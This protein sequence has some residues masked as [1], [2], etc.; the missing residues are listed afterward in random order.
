MSTV[1]S[2][3]RN[4]IA[5]SDIFMTYYSFMFQESIYKTSL[6]TYDLIRQNQ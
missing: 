6:E 4:H 3:I 5:K 1:T 2:D